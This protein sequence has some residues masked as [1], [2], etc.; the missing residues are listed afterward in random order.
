M[1]RWQFLALLAMDDRSTPRRTRWGCELDCRSARACPKHF[2][3]A[4]LLESVS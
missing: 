4:N 1:P 2:D 3:L